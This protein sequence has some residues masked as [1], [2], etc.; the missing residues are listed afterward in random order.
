LIASESL[1]DKTS[2]A[3]L[4]DRDLFR[5]VAAA[6]RLPGREIDRVAGEI[7]MAVAIQS[8]DA[9]RESAAG[10]DVVRQT[11]PAKIGADAL[12]QTAA[13]IDIGIIRHAHVVVH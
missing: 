4:I 1:T 11:V 12:G 6:Q 5:P 3:L 7:D 10:R 8:E 9:L 2:R 13:A